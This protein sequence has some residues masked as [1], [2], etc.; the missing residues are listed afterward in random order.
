MFVAMLDFYIVNVATI[1]FQRELHAGD[2][3]LELIVGGYLV[4]FA[5]GMITAGRLGDLHGH[6]RLFI[7]GMLSFAAASLLC[8]LAPNAW[9][10][11]VFR[12]LQGATA[13]LMVPQSLALI[14]TLFPPSERG[15]ATSVFGASIGLGAVSGQVIGG[16][17]LSANIFDWGWR[18]IFYINVPIGLIAA[19][20]AVRYLPVRPSV[21]HPKLDPI[22]AIGIS[23]SVAL[24]VVA[25]ALGRPQGWPAWIWICMVLAAALLALTIGY[26]GRLLRAGGQPVLDIT[27]VHSRGFALGL[28][29]VGAY[30]AFLG[31]FMITFAQL[32]QQGLHQSPLRAGLTVAPLALCFA[33]SS[34]F[35]AGRVSRRIGNRVMVVGPCVSLVGMALTLVLL[36]HSGANISVLA[37]IPGTMLIGVGHGLTI[38]SVIGAVLSTGVPPQKAGMAA[39]VLTTCQQFGNAIGSTVLGVIFFST[40]ASG[41]HTRDYVHAMEAASFGAVVLLLIVVAA[42]SGLP[43]KRR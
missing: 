22:G 13:A 14:N 12:I 36:Y 26:E 41:H 8:G 31:G 40:L 35:L 5:S 38:T 39:G 33:G 16:L 17:L 27:I 21:A 30:L 20:L 9:A 10:L 19:A 25:M 2:S 29:I 24:L 15:K 11:V 28:V 3:A 42:A 6:R 18:S 37:L 34:Y 1:S 4:A 43:R 23:V 32:L 7:I